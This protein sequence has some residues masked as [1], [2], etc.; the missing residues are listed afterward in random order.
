MQHEEIVKQ[1]VV[2]AAQDLATAVHTAKTM[3]PTPDEI[4]CFYCQ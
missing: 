1:W 2:L 4:I 3:W